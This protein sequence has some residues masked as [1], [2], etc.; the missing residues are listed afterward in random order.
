MDIKNLLFNMLLAGL[1]SY[2]ISNLFFYFANKD[3]NKKY[4]VK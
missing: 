3:R 1:T 4:I 2:I